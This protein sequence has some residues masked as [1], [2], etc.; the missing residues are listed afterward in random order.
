MK[1]GTFAQFL[2]AFAATGALAQEPDIPRDLIADGPFA[3]RVKGLACNSS[4]DGYLHTT[5]VQAYP[6]PLLYLNYDPSSAPQVDN[7]SYRFYFN[8]TGRMQSDA[9]HELGFFVSD[10]TVGELNGVG[11]LG[12]AMSLQ[13]RPNTNVAVQAF[14]ANTLQVDLT[15]FDRDGKAFLFYYRDDA[16]TVPNKPNYGNGEILYYEWALC[17]ETASGTTLRT[18]S[19]ITAGKPRNPTCERVQLIKSKLD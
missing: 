16:D 10:I 17:W 19:W 11:L 1:I 6:V 9:G 14:G 18:L 8:Y 12:K 7:S 3:F 5:E 2:G 4:I 13:Y 15:G